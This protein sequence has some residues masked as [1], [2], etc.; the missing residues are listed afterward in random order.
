[1]LNRPLSSLVTQA[2][3]SFWSA[4]QLGNQCMRKK[5]Q[6][7]HATWPLGVKRWLDVSS[8]LWTQTL[9]TPQ[10]AFITTSLFVGVGLVCSGLNFL[11]PTF[12][13]CPTYQAGISVSVK[14]YQS[15][16]EP[17][18]LACHNLLRSK[19]LWTG[20]TCAVNLFCNNQLFY[21]VATLAQAFVSQ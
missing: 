3:W 20:C 2:I 11:P 9:P 12:G 10:S 19:F 1:M 5:M 7:G 6:N 8:Q 14:C 21:R 16:F 17:F 4:V 15:L 13:N 18:V